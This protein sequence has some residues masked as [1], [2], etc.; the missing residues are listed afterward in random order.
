MRI[1]FVRHA[2]SMANIVNALDTAAPGAS[3]S[4]LGRQQAEA[5]PTALKAEVDEP[6]TAVYASPL[7]RTQETAEPLARSLGLPVQVRVGLQ[8]VLAGDLE[9]RGDDESIQQYLANAQAWAS[10]DLDARL[11]GGETGHE[12]LA[13]MDGVVEEAVR[14]GAEAVAMVSHGCA[15]WTWVV[16]RAGNLGAG[17]RPPNAMSNTALVAVAGDLDRGW[18]VTSWEGTVLHDPGLV[19]TEHDGPVNVPGPYAT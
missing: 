10:G 16:A 4:P 12:V 8:E 15:I 3:L 7:R 11:P 17:V 18:R 14:S 13:R 9:G 6:I 1:L 2:Q 5:L 19:D